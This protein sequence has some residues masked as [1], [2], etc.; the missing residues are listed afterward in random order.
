MWAG[1]PVNP[2]Y[3]GQWPLQYWENGEVAIDSVTAEHQSW[4]T[5]WF[6]EKSVDF[7]NRHHDKPFFLYVPHPQ[8]HV[9]LFVSEKF[10]GASGTGLYGDVMMELDWSVGEIM[11]ALKAHGIDQHTMVLCNGRSSTS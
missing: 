4:F 11:T 2:G 5:T 10:A 7:I 3:W 1:H 9:P 8:P 6:T